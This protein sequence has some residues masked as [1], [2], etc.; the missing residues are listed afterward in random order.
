MSN[1]MPEEAEEEVQPPPFDMDETYKH[2]NENAI[3]M[4]MWSKSECLMARFQE[5]SLPM[6]LYPSCYM[7]VEQGAMLL[8]WTVDKEKEQ[9]GYA[10]HMLP[11]T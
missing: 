5:L 6:E 11:Q 4:D 7:Q 3:P 10:L 8:M 1:R 9:V 2:F